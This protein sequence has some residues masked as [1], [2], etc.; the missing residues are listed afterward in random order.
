M[1][2]IVLYRD[3]FKDAFR[4]LNVEWLDKYNLREE[5]DMIVLNDPQGKII[6]KGG[7]I[8]IAKEGD[9][10]VGTA[11]MVPEH[12]DV[13]ELAKMAVTEQWQGR[14]ISKLLLE[15]CLTWAKEKQA[16]KVELFSNSQ[17]KSALG[18]YEKYGFVYVDV[19]DSPFVT[20]DIKME[21]HLV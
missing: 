15:K 5:A 8:Y 17:L 14:G 21:L 13:Y 1:T 19:K 12:N 9:E 11:A 3:E 10:V 20:A 7:V 6:D 2:E 4:Q 16:V 18:L